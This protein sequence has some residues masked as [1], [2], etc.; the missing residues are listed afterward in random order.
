M[1]YL[2]GPAVVQFN[3]DCE[4]GEVIGVDVAIRITSRFVARK[5]T[6]NGD[7]GGDKDCSLS[8]IRNRVLSRFSPSDIL[9]GNSSVIIF[10]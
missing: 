5:V 4:W 1:I 2:C 9:S 8:F 7:T 6:T 10:C 3:T